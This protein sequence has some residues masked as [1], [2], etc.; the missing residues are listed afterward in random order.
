MRIFVHEYTCGGGLAGLAGSDSLRAEGLAMLTAVL[1]DLARVPGTEVSTLLE[2]GH[3]VDPAVR[4]RIV[5]PGEE[6][7]LFRAEA[8]AADITLAI[9]PETDGILRTRQRWVEEAGG[10]WLGGSAAALELTGDKLALARHLLVRNVPTPQSHLV[11]PGQPF[12][13]VSYPAVLKPRHGAGSQATFLL[14]SAAELVP[15]QEQ[16]K[17]EGYPGELILQPFAAGQPASV[18]LLVGPR[19]V[20]P[21]VPAEQ[22][23][24]DDGRFHY[25][26]GVLPLSGVL[27]E[28]A[29]TLALRVAQ[30][31]EG[32][33]GYVGVDLVLGSAA[34]GSED[35]AIEINPRLTTSYV[36]LRVLA[37]ANLAERLLR[38][39]RGEDIPP[40]RWQSGP[41]F[42]HAS[43]AV[44]TP[45]FASAIRS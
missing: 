2:P 31:V 1:R 34:D 40:I 43:G 24:S 39:W 7:E 16:A 41:V 29:V 19:C 8:K 21:L 37:E 36:G 15:A 28:R 22:R 17:A 10:R 5:D 9:A 6:E 23:L 11:L 33:A 27:A 18:A 30:A 3:A 12:S 4:C 13:S 45:D 32:L 35:W 38:V 44:A 42:F 20:V 26:G 14:R 25:L